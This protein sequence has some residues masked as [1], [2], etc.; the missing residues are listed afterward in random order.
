MEIKCQSKLFLPKLSIRKK[1]ESVLYPIIDIITLI[2]LFYDSNDLWL[3]YQR[4]HFF[5]F[6]KICEILPHLLFTKNPRKIHVILY[7]DI[8]MYSSFQ[9]STLWPFSCLWTNFEFFFYN[10]FTIPV[11][12]A[13]NKLRRH[14]LLWDEKV[15]R[16][17]KE[18]RRVI[19]TFS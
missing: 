11:K 14:E 9:I 1:D 19:K 15:W 7:L 17:K 6:V 3:T 12:E 4:I 5:H 8:H 18:K 2:T 10:L 13:L 16:D